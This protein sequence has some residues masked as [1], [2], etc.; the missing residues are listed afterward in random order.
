MPASKSVRGARLPVGP[1]LSVCRLPPAVLAGYGVGRALQADHHWDDLHTSRAPASRSGRDHGLGHQVHTKDDTIPNDD[2]LKDTLTSLVFAGTLIVIIIRAETSHPARA[3]LL[4]LAPDGVDH[5]GRRST[6]GEVPG[7]ARA[8]RG[9]LLPKV[10]H[11]V[12]V[13]SYG[14]TIWYHAGWYDGKYHTSR[15]V[16]SPSSGSG[17]AGPTAAAGGGAEQKAH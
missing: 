17:G 3:K 10:P 12:L 1:R 16:G 13:R 6:P 9:A 14:T 11:G 8:A 4:G 5:V 7:A 15:A 2:A